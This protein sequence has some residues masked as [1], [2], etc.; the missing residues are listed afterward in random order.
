MNGVSKR[1]SHRLLQPTLELSQTFPEIEHRQGRKILATIRRRE[2]PPQ[3]MHPCVK[4]HVNY[5]H[6]M[7]KYPDTYLKRCMIPATKHMECLSDHSHW[8]PDQKFEYLSFLE[9]FKVFSEARY[10]KHSD[11]K[12]ILREGAATVLSLASPDKIIKS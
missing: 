6:C 2:A 8:E 4:S 9:H 10:Y 11:P 7:K 5:L 1:K 12:A 3:T